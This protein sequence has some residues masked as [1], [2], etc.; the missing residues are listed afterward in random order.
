MNNEIAEEY[1]YNNN[2][3]IR[4]FHTRRSFARFANSGPSGTNRFFAKRRDGTSPPRSI[5]ETDVA[6]DDAEEIVG[7]ARSLTRILA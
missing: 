2:F 1:I 5:A 3:I 6:V 4:E 7:P